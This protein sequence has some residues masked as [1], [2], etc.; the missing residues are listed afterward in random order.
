MNAATTNAKTRPTN[1]ERA[2][3]WQSLGLLGSGPALF[4]IARAEQSAMTKI[5][6]GG[7]FFLVPLLA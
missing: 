1:N 2:A 7:R 6:S 4:E 3:N 5:K